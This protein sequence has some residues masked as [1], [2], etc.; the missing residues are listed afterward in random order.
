MSKLIADFDSQRWLFDRIIKKIPAGTLVTEDAFVAAVVATE[1]LDFSSWL[2][3]MYPMRRSITLA[4]STAASSAAAD[5]EALTALPNPSASAFVTALGQASG[6]GGAG[7]ASAS[8]GPEAGRGERQA[9]GGSV[10]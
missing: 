5:Y 8:A 3:R 9:S 4:I 2:T 1:D 10:S 7:G 6:A